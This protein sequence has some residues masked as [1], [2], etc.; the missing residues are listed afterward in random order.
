[1]QADKMR[2]R[3]KLKRIKLN[4]P[5]RSIHYYN[6]RYWLLHELRQLRARRKYGSAT[7]KDIKVSQRALAKIRMDEHV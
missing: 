6:I 7:L 2:I 1:M 3:L 4:P 5:K